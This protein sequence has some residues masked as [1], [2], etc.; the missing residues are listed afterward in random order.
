MKLLA[1]N[2]DEEFN[3]Q[4]AIC[5]L[6]ADHFT[7][8]LTLQNVTAAPTVLFYHHVK[9]IDRVDGFN[10]SDLLKKIKFHINKIGIIPT[11]KIES[12]NDIDLNVENRIKELLQSSPIILFM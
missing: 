11:S 6:N 7:D 10:Q 5:R 9:L 2:R 4:L 1:I 8:F 12:K 3:Q